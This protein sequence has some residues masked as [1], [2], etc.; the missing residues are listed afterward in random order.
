ML[1]LWVLWRIA[2]AGLPL[3]IL[4]VLITALSGSVHRRAVIAPRS[5]ATAV[6]RH[7]AAAALDG[8]R[9][10]LTRTLEGR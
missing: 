9:G 10:L 7:D 5:P 3:V 8:A 4:A 6:V 1:R 2:R